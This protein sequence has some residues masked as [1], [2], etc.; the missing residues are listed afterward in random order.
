M[1]EEAQAVLMQ[2][3][4]LLQA[5]WLWY[6]SEPAPPPAHSVPTAYPTIDSTSTTHAEDVSQTYGAESRLQQEPEMDAARK[7]QLRSMVVQELL[8][9]CKTKGPPHSVAQHG[10]TWPVFKPKLSP[11]V[12]PCFA[13]FG[14]RP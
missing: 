10:V 11:D 12:H 13:L 8:H 4:L 1:S 2:H 9:A 7:Q 3:Q 5:A 14:H 6:I